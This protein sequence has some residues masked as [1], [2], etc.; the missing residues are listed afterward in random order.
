MGRSP[1]ASTNRNG[2]DE[3]VFP[4]TSFRALMLSNDASSDR[5]SSVKRSCRNSS[6]PALKLG[7]DST[8]SRHADSLRA[9]L[10]QPASL[11]CSPSLPATT[12]D[13]RQVFQPRGDFVWR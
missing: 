2:H 7:F 10:L 13:F 4:K 8:S 5:G 6:L 12:S 3:T 9:R 1:A 11:P